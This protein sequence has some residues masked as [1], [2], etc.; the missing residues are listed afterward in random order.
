MQRFVTLFFIIGFANAFAQIPIHTKLNGKISATTPDLDGV[1]VIN[2]KNEAATITENGGYF[3]ITA[4]PGDTL[5]FSAVQFV[6]IR[7]VLEQKYFENELFFVKLETKIN[8]LEEVIVKKYDNINAVSL[9]IVP[10]GIKHYTPAERKYATATSGK[11]NPMGLDP[12]LNFISGRTAMLKKEIEVEK[13]ENYLAQIN[14]LFE[15]I[16][17]IEKLKI[18]PDYVKGFQYYI[19]DNERFVR[20]LKSKN[21]TNIEFV[22]GELAT[23]YFEILVNEK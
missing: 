18:P 3:S 6:G 22:M 20:V 8:Q 19:I 12:L 10:K 1:Y 15:K 17:F 7:I 5:M 21:K 14:T 16:F 9:G 4:A 2:L 13:K 23:K 11:L